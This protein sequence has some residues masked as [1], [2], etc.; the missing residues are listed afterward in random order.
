[1][2]GGSGVSHQGRD[3]IQIGWARFLKESTTKRGGK[4]RDAL[5]KTLRTG[6]KKEKSPFQRL[7]V[8]QSKDPA[9][10]VKI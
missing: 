7:V 1:L 4:S 10:E 2:V 3:T 6:E 8:I 9:A 5:R